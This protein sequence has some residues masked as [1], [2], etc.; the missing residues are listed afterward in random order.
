MKTIKLVHV[1]LGDLNKQEA[2]LLMEKVKTE[3][4]AHGCKHV[5]T[6]PTVHGVPQIFVE[7][8]PLR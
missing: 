1:E 2:E 8:L 5:I 6:V 3:F 4:E 7:E